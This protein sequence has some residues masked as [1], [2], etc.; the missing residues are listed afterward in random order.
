M[1][2]RIMS[3]CVLLLP[4]AVAHWLWCN[5]RIP[6]GSWAPHVLGRSMGGNVTCGRVK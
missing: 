3:I 1:G 6:L 2:D 5:E 4:Q